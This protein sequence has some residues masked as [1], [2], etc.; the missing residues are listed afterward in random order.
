[1]SAVCITCACL[2][3]RLLIENWQRQHHLSAC[4]LE[5]TENNITTADENKPQ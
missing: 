5:I 3:S 2:G 1:M 4:T